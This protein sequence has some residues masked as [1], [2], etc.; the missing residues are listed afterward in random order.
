MKVFECNG[1]S[2]S[3]VVWHIQSSQ[4]SEMCE[5]LVGHLSGKQVSLALNA[6]T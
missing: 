2:P 5:A 4:H 6:C 3:V 1:V